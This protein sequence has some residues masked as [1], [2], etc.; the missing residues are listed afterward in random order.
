MN[1][2]LKPQLIT[3]SLVV[4]DDGV[5]DER[6][7]TTKLAKEVTDKIQSLI[8]EY[9]LSVEWISTSYNQLPSIKSA[10]C[11]NCGA[12]TTDSM[13]NEKVGA[14]YYLLNAGTLY[15][16]RLLCDLCLPEDHPLYF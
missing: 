16:G 11:E 9:E 1:E 13:S 15:E 3:I 2:D 6:F 12:W 14:S 7:G 4:S 10:R 5:E 8:D